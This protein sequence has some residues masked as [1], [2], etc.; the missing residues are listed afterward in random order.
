MVRRQSRSGMTL[1]E[2][3]VVVAILFVVLGT[4]SAG[5]FQMFDCTVVDREHQGRIQRATIEAIRNGAT[6]AKP[7]GGDLELEVQGSPVLSG[8][9]VHT[10]LQ[11]RVH[12]RL[13]YAVQEGQTAIVLPIALGTWTSAA[14]VDASG[15]LP[16]TESMLAEGF[17][18]QAGVGVLQLEW[19]RHD[20]DEI[21]LEL[22]PETAVLDGTVVVRGGSVQGANPGEPHR[23]RLEPGNRVHLAILPGPSTLLQAR[24]LGLYGAFGMLLFG[25]GLW[26]TSEG[27]RP[28]MLEHFRLP[29]LLLLGLN[30]GLFYA[31]AVGLMVATDLPLAPSIA[32]AGLLATPLLSLHL[33]ALTDA[34]FARTRALPLGVSTWALVT[35][36]AGSSEARLLL[37]SATSVVVL[38]LLT[39]TWKPWSAA[40][41][42]W[43]EQQAEAAR[44]ERW[45][46]RIEGAAQQ[47]ERQVA[48]QWGRLE[49]AESVIRSLPPG[50]GAARGVVSRSQHRLRALMARAEQELGRPTVLSSEAAVAARIE[51]LKRTTAH[52][53][54]EEA[55]LGTA[56][57][58]LMTAADRVEHEVAAALE[59]LARTCDQVALELGDPAIVASRRALELRVEQG[60]T[61]LLL[62]AADARTLTRSAEQ[63]LEAGRQ[64]R[65]AGVH[66][67]A[68]GERHPPGARYCGGC[69]TPRALTLACGACGGATLLPVGVLRTD[70]QEAPLHCAACG[71]GLNAA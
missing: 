30:Y 70:W 9:S 59:A 47:L 44:A 60:G 61:D 58:G 3:M 55:A 54:L 64:T 31:V 19:E 14:W 29:G 57:D 45:A 24:D 71:G 22:A 18:V 50:L 35:L 52:L 65:D 68:C 49:H 8:L 40:R 5:V 53:E 66:C 28:G 20:L 34:V 51:D 17:P 21:E 33:V 67:F 23:F 42:A 27:E 39:W 12:G 13:R 25:V 26:Y 46:H 32:L 48:L 62:L 2:V 10:A 43:F 38:A 36:W 41:A 6:V 7:L 4:L 15:T 37:A 1:V 69:G 56:L 11:T 16:L 63:V